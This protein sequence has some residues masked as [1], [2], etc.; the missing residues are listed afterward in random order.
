MASGAD[1]LVLVELTPEYMRRFQVAGV[2]TSY[3]HQALAPGRRSDRHRHLLPATPA[4]Q[5]GTVDFGDDDR[6]RGRR[7]SFGDGTLRIVGVHTNAPK[8]GSGIDSWLASLDALDDFTNSPGLGPTVMAGDFNATRWHPAM[9]TIMD[10]PFVDAHEEVGKGLT[11]SWP[12]DQGPTSPL[13]RPISP[14]A[15][16]DHA[17]VHDVGVASVRDDFHAAGSDHL[18][19]MVTVVPQE[20]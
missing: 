6:S 19:F 18:P 13:L 5:R 4:R 3:P 7:G 1:V 14:F 10:G 8:F 11:S 16:L 12:A 17:L 15:R 9:R 2:D 20:E